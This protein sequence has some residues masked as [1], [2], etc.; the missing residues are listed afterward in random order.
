MILLNQW[1]SLLMQKD[2]C[3]NEENVKEFD[4]GIKNANREI[5][6]KRVKHLRE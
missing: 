5:L 2:K 3:L 6:R 1:E 4:I